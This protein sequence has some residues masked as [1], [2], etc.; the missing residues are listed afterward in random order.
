MMK[1]L[2]FI[3]YFSNIISIN[4]II[5][6]NIYSFVYTTIQNYGFKTY[7]TTQ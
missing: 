6:K 7:N 3:H 1:A 5:N 2:L 4:N